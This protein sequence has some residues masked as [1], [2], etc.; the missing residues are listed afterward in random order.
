MVKSRIAVK[1]S[2]VRAR[3]INGSTEK[4]NT[5]HINVH[6]LWDAKVGVP[7]N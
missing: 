1:N 6:G 4:L 3:I 2:N 7:F 5:F